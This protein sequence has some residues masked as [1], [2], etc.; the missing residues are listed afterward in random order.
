[1]GTGVLQ[2]HFPGLIFCSLVFPRAREGSVGLTQIATVSPVAKHVVFTLVML[3]AVK[4]L[5]LASLN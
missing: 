4:H 5:H 3:N 1:V 2:A